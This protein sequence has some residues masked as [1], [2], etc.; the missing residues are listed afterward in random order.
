MKIHYVNILLFAL[1]LNIFAHNKNKP[2]IV[3][4]TPTKKPIKSHRTLC[5]CELY[6]S[7]Y[8]NDQE[9]KKLMENFDRQISQRFHEYDEHMKDKRQKCKEQ[10]NKDIQKIILQ[11]KIEKELAEHF[12]ALETKIDTNDIPTCVCEKS[13]SDKMEKT[14]LKCTQNLG[15]IVVPSSGVLGGIAELAI[16]VCKPKAIAAAI[17]I[18]K[19]AGEAA[20]A[21]KGAAKGLEAVISGLKTFGIDDLSPGILETFFSTR[22]Y[23]D[24]SSL[25]RVIY[26][27]YQ[28]TC[29][30]WD[31]STS[32][33]PVC[34]NAGNKLNLIPKVGGPV[35]DPE[36]AIEA[37]V[38]EAV[39]EAT[40]IATEAAKTTSQSVTATIT[41]QKTSEIA[42]TYMGYEITIVAPIVAILVIL[43][44]MVIIYLILRYR[45][46]KKMKKK[47]EYIKLLKE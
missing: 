25:P 9:M 12:S 47:L 6:T 28:I 39:V 27:K 8:D 30:L 36:V 3:L 22:L 13:L 26:E 45:R 10:C 43:L 33:N 5:E 21:A 41:K 17:A 7:I 40:E 42:A 23:N 1:P 32:S 34:T 38:T 15:G 46:K 2:H 4:H 14:C 18:A 37:K 31:V 20:G 29:D 19:E 11:D 16:S 44:V 35:V 24:V